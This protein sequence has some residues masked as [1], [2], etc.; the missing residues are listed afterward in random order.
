LL[1]CLS[2]LKEYDANLTTKIKL[3]DSHL[4]KLYP[5]ENVL[6]QKEIKLINDYVVGIKQFKFYTWN[7]KLQMLKDFIDVN[8]FRPRSYAK[9]KYELCISQWLSKQ[10]QNYKNKKE[11][12]GIQS[13]YDSW[14]EF[15]N[16]SKYM[17]YIKNKNDINIES[18]YKNFNLLKEFIDVNNK[19]PN[20]K[21]NNESERKLAYWIDAQ[22]DN[23]KNNKMLN[24]EIKKEWINFKKIRKYFDSVKT[25]K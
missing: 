18:W 21:N 2:S 1:D 4:V 16:D 3:I 8:N 10:I 24:E 14:T 17:N 12:M 6:V 13:K 15:I 11:S 25:K 7:E 23:F 19:R 9:D 20:D 22:N 5:D